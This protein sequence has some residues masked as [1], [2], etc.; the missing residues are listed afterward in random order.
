MK[1]K[2]GIIVLIAIVLWILVFCINFIKFENYKEPILTEKGGYKHI[3]MYTDSNGT[4]HVLYNMFFDG[5]G[6]RIYYN[7][8][9]NNEIV[10][11]QFYIFGIMVREKSKI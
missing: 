4:E 11:G 10:R 3:D 9:K 2:I 5:I 7:T 8:E 6:Y 1:K